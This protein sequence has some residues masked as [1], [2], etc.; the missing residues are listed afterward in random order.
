MKIAIVGA[1]FCGLAATYFLQDHA[2]VELFD[3]ERIG[4]GASGLTAGLLHPYAGPKAVKSYRADEAMKAT[5]ELLKV[6]SL[7]T[8]SPVYFECGMLRPHVAGM[9]FSE[10]TEYDDV[11]WWDAATCQAHIPELEAHPGLF[12]HSAI[13]V[14]CPAY[15]EGLWKACAL[16]GAT[17]TQASITHPE[18]LTG[19]DYVI[20]TVGAGQVAL[21]GVTCPPI[22]LIKGETLE[23]EWQK[24]TPLPFT[25][26]AGVQFT[27]VS[28]NTVW[29][30]ATY[31]RKWTEF[32]NPEEEIRKKVALFSEQFSRLPLKRIWSS[33][34]AA[35]GDKKPFISFTAPNVYCLGGMGS[36]GLLYHALMA[37]SLTATL[38][39]DA[40]D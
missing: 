13:T 4:A 15:L 34:R 33:F 14:N 26:N 17:F 32:D 30:G 16:K 25:I 7:H 2:Q 37:A 21:K 1:G 18:E 39:S 6:A 36:K 19:Y 31:K 9:N 38:F 12:I 35:T 27:Q 29:A 20:F 11:E 22:S 3:K 40:K 23:L 5:K 24:P 8:D 10:R 28:P